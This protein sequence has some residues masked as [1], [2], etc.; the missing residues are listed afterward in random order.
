MFVFACAGCGGEV[1]APVSQVELPVHAYQKS[2]N[3]VQLPVLMAQGTFAVDPEPSGQPWRGWEEIDPDE[4]AARGVYAPVTGLSYGV[5]G[6]V[7]IAPGDVRGTLLVP[8]ENGSACCGLAGGD[9]PN[10]VCEVCGLP[11]A[12]RID[13]CSLWQAVWLAPDAVRRVRVDGDDAVPLSWGELAA[14]GRSTPPVVPITAWGS[15]SGLYHRWSWN[16]QWEAAAGRA[17][18]HLL[19]ASGGRTVALPNGLARDV[20]QRAL[21]TLL[22]AGPAALRAD[23]A[24]PGLSGADADILFVPTHPQTG[25]IWSPD[26]SAQCVP[27]PFGVW[28]SL[29]LPEPAPLPLIASGVMP[30][31][32]LRDEPLA[33]HP[34]TPFR[35]DQNA[36]E[37]ALVRLPAV[38]RPWLRRIL[39]H[40][41]R[42]VRARLF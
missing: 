16:P 1:T 18:A 11:V 34:G 27:L 30:D 35:I 2:G 22:P 4:A 39:D 15:S 14:H 13:D 21:D 20:F 33:P 5:P 42:P 10:M 41:T 37:Y 7:V 6:A 40:L 29:A 9:G 36:F 3:A 8:E 12:T 17:L 26:A 24:G 23:F 32:V 25:E 28:L 38:R 31:G 19:V